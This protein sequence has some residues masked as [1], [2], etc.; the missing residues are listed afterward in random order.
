MVGPC[1]GERGFGQVLGDLYT[2]ALWQTQVAT[3]DGRALGR[4]ALVG[5]YP[6]LVLRME[7]GA[8][9]LLRVRGLCSTSG[10]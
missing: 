1:P 4:R 10:L 2:W 3:L 8:A 6:L 9:V 5:L 7:T